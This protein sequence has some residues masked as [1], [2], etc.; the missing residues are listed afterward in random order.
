MYSALAMY[1]AR[2]ETSRGI[3]ALGCALSLRRVTWII[4]SMPS[5]MP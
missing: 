1:M 2:P 5:R 3:P 4:R